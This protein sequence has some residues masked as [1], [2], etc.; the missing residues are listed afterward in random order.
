ME[1]MSEQELSPSQEQR[2]IKK[3]PS[4]LEY[5]SYIFF[6]S[7]FLTGPVAEFR[8]YRE[9][10]DRSMFV[11]EVAALPQT[12]TSVL[13]YTVGVLMTREATYQRA[14]GGPAPNGL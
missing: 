10:V 11:K 13:P 6:F 3:L 1:W 2:A 7:G 9:F 12:L 14:R 5:F 8:E 4:L